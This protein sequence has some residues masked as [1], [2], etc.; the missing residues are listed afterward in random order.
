MQAAS[1]FDAPNMSFRDAVKLSLQP[2]VFMRSLFASVV[3]W[4]VL[5]SV[6]PSYARLI[7]HGELSGYFAAGLA[8]VLASQIISISDHLALELGF[9][10]NGC[11]AE[12][13]GGGARA[14]GGRR[15]GG[16]AGRYAA[17]D[18]VCGGVLDDR[19]VINSVRDI[20]YFCLGWYAL[21]GSS[22]TFPI[23]LSADSWRPWVG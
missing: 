8:I 9:V 21:A 2:T 13:V 5:A 20:S 11:A 19:A 12:S 14:A 7:F 1:P 15:H 4:L 10:D 3:I 6:T 17:R 23:R 18:A 22:D 16:G